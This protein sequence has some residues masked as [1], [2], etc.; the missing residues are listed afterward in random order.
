MNT[1]ITGVWQALLPPF[2]AERFGRKGRFVL[3][4]AAHQLR[5]KSRPFVV[6]M[7]ACTH[8]TVTVAVNRRA[9]PSAY[10]INADNAD[11]ASPVTVPAGVGQSTTASGASRTNKPVNRP[12]I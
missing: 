9:R 8:V 7:P 2:P 10:A 6:A 4:P 5:Q 3:E 1:P 12:L 11:N